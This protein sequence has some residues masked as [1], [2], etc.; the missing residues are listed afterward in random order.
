M[1]FLRRFFFTFVQLWKLLTRFLYADFF[2]FLACLVS[3]CTYSMVSKHKAYLLS[4]LNEGRSKS[5]FPQLRI[6]T[7]W[8]SKGYGAGKLHIAI[9]FWAVEN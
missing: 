4:G 8:P 1:A 6:N 5:N 7:L 3:M 9:S 2:I